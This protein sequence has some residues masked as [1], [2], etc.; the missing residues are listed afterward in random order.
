MTHPDSIKKFWYDQ[1]ADAPATL[2]KMKNV[3]SLAA[4]FNAN[5]DSVVKMSGTVLT[6]MIARSGLGL[7]D[8]QNVSVKSIRTAFASES[9]KNG[10]P[11]TWKFTAG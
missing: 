1:Y 11:K 10:L 2:A 5:V 4:A 9:P 3:G 8:L 6:Q 7:S